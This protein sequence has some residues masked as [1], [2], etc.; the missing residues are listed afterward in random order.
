MKKRFTKGVLGEIITF[1]TGYWTE[2]LIPCRKFLLQKLAVPQTAKNLTSFMELEIPLP[3]TQE[4]AFCPQ[5]QP[6]KS[7]VLPS[8]F[9]KTL[10]YILIY[11]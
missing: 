3:P 6:D 2:G 8:C 5:P 11:V 10:Y 7:A 4:P 9:F 1:V